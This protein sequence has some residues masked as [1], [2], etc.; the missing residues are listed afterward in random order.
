M[1]VEHLVGNA[2]DDRLAEGEVEARQL[3]QA[4][5]HAPDQ[6]LLAPA[7]WPGVV[8]AQPDAGLGVRRRPGI[9]AVVVASGVG[10]DKRYFG[11]LAE[12]RLAVD[13]SVEQPGKDRPAQQ[14]LPPL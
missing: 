1:R 8:G 11:K 4:R 9:G 7:G 13:P 5:V 3:V 12:H 14:R 2:I 6:V 10:D